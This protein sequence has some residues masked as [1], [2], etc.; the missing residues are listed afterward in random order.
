MTLDSP[1]PDQQAVLDLPADASGTVI[2]APGTGKTSLLVERVARLV[3]S[4]AVAPGEVLV[5]TPTR[6]SATRLRD[7]LGVR[8]GVATPGP[9]ARSVGSLAFQ[10][11]RAGAVHRGEEPPQ[12]LTGADQDRIVAEILAG[13]EEDEAEGRTR[14][15]ARLGPLVR[16][17]QGFRSELR[18]FLAE[19]AELAVE[20]GEL[21]ALGDETWQ[22]VAGFVR[23]YRNVL[24]GMREAHRESAELQAE[25]AAL[26]RAL[27]ADG[28]LGEID[29]LRLVLIDDAQ[30]LTRGGIA[31]V[32]AL[33]ARGTSVLAAGD[34][35]I[36]SGAFRGV[37]PELFA[38]L[39][40]VLGP[41]HVVSGDHRSHPAIARLGRVVTQQIGAG[42]RVD[43]R[44][45]PGPE[46]DD[47]GVAAARVVSSPHEEATRVAWALRSWH[48]DDGVPWERMA[49]IAHDTRQVVALEAELAAREVPTRAAGVPRP[50]GSERAVRELVEIVRLGLLPPAERDDE[51]L[52]T[53]LRSPFGGFDGVALRRLRARLRHHEL[54]DDGMRP[55]RELLREALAQ[56][57]LFDAVDTA[58]AR[59]AK[60]FGVTLEHL[61]ALGEAGATIHELLWEAWDRART[62]D[63]RRL[64]EAWHELAVSAHP[65]AAET[66]RAL[67]G[68]VALFDAAKRFVERFPDEG[69]ARFIHDILDS[70]VPED[71]LSTPERPGAVALLTPASAL[72]LEFDAVAIAGVQDGVWPNVRLRGGLLDTW[73]LAD[74]V[75]ARREGAGEPTVPGTLD[76]RRSALHDELRLFVRALSRARSRVLVT[77]VS[78][79]DLTPSPL[80]DLLPDEPGGGEEESLAHPLTLRG[81]VSDLR[82]A[83]TEGTDGP[84]AARELAIL[85]REGVPGADPAQ[86][87]GAAE[88]TTAAP[89]VDPHE[90]AVRVSPSRMETFE[91]CGLDW[92][93]RALGGDTA[94]SPSSG[95]GTILHAALETA[96]DGDLERMSAV[97]DERWGELE[98]ESPWIARRERARAED[99]IRNLHRYARAAA[100]DGGRLLAAEAPFE[101][102]VPFDAERAEPGAAERADAA[103]PDPDGTDRVIGVP[104]DAPR[105]EGLG[106]HALI[107][108]VIDRVEAY[109]RGGGEYTAARGRGPQPIAPRDADAA[110]Q[111][112]IA[113]LKTGRYEDRLSDAK[114]TGDAQLAAYQLAVDAGLVPGADPDALAGA[115]L[116][117]VS[118]ATGAQAYRVAHQPALGP[119]EREAFL[120]RV[121]EAARGMSAASFVARVEAHCQGSHRPTLC[122]PHTVRAV[123]AP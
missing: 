65:L 61:H 52:V 86:W 120:A 8:V 58:E 67:D 121:A 116:V 101:L 72:G 89:L 9:L 123:S 32:E 19:L 16:R 115:R 6:P 47:D 27:P 88:P 77:A 63:G 99:A 95:L 94:A 106:P 75:Q 122:R 64:A 113:D 5:L 114:V 79:D 25:A 100:A 49:V 118:P 62:A 40:G 82:R 83:L 112:V 31:L 3:A 107:R 57:A 73:R 104:E 69:A 20:P 87:Y 102:A 15:P 1:D 43:H 44:R 48:L 38:R 109:P 24:A 71:S 53:A 90:R 91:E 84:G 21:E 29:R 41:V 119:E 34:P 92:A 74:A 50:L 11:V 39:V 22:A 59:A 78:D 10:I 12:L 108:G 56:P 4:G 35:D 97:L 70:D 54:A 46:V 93:I 2:G 110:E 17:S 98:F 76:R 81:L 14:W 105:P 80:L 45:P 51:A 60:R 36:G 42:G 18:A 33:Q 68:L 30:E 23:D 66:G 111:V 37:T 117:V 85:A 103:A 55:A 7:E 28:A 96:P 13:D 26:L